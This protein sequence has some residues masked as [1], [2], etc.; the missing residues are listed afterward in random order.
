MC[1]NLSDH[2]LHTGCGTVRMEATNP[3]PVI[4]TPKEREDPSV[5]LKKVISYKG[6]EGT[7]EE[8]DTE[9]PQTREEM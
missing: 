9:E 6:R 4:N 3:K 1:L 8:R 5:T 7:Q 2:E